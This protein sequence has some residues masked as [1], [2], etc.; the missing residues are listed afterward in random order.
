MATLLMVIW[1][2]TRI[3]RHHKLSEQPD[4]VQLLELK[5][6]LHN[7]C[8][9]LTCAE[10]SKVDL[11]TRAKQT[12]SYAE[13][14]CKKLGCAKK[15]IDTLRKAKNTL[16]MC[17]TRASQMQDVAVE[18]SKKDVKNLIEAVECHN[19]RQQVITILV[20]EDSIQVDIPSDLDEEESDWE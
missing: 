19:S 20:D 5:Q 9:K 13:S 3:P 18:K 17:V 16:C 8:C 4:S 10:A 14:S 11:H 6:K 1:A 7:T 15:I 12:V 2:I